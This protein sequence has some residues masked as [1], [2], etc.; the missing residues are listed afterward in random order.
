[1]G[2]EAGPWEEEGEVVLWLWGKGVGQGPAE[3]EMPAAVGGRGSAGAEISNDA[4]IICP[5]KEHYQ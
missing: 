5:K 3:Q 4:S 1:M 2:Q